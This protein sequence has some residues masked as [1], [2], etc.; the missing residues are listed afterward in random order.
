MIF[1]INTENSPEQ[2]NPLFSTIE[3][4]LTEQMKKLYRRE[5]VFIQ[6]IKKTGVML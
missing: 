3:T 4:V 1:T 2:L 5:P 6:S